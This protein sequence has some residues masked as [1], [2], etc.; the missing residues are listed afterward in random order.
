MSAPQCDQW[1]RSRCDCDA[2]FE[3]LDP[4][5]VVRGKYCRQHGRALC[6]DYEEQLGE[7]WTLR[8]LELAA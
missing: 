6:R 5:R 7:L 1:K 3:M 8:A 4:D 2:V